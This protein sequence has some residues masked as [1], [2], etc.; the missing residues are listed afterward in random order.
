MV[1]Q[2]RG[3]TSPG[4]DTKK[5]IDQS[6]EGFWRWWKNVKKKKCDKWLLIYMEKGTLSPSHPTPH[7]PPHPTQPPDRHMHT[8][9]ACWTHF[10]FTINLS[11]VEILDECSL[12]LHD[13]F[14]GSLVKI[15]CELWPFISTYHHIYSLIHTPNASVSITWVFTRTPN[16]IVI[17]LSTNWPKRFTYNH[18]VKTLPTPHASKLLSF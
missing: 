4:C 16:L 14:P 2:I 15:H 13:I 5:K 8:F 17:F 3:I 11:K 6:P 7:L 18:H 1:I 12:E 9:P 10:M